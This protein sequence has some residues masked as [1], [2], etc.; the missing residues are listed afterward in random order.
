MGIDCIVSKLASRVPRTVSP[1]WG[2]GGIFGL[3]YT[4]E[5]LY[6]TVAFDAKAYFHHDDCSTEIYGYEYI[7]E[8]PRSGGDTYNAATRVDNK[9]YFGGWVH[10]PAHY[11]PSTRG[12]GE[13]LFTDKYSHVHEYDIAERKTKLLWSEK[14][15]NPR[16][17]VGEITDLLY[18]PLRDSLLVA[19][20]DGHINLGVYEIDRRKGSS[21]QVTR[22]R[23]LRSAIYADH[24]CFTLHHGWGGTP[25]IT[26]LDL[27]SYREYGIAISNPREISVDNGPLPIYRSG[28]IAALDTWIISLIRGGTITYD[29]LGPEKPWF[30]RLLDFHNSP[31]GPLRSNALSIG[32]GLLVAF[33]ASTHSTITGTDELPPEQ[34]RAARRPPAQ[35]LLVYLSP[36]TAR[37]IA[38]LGVRVTSMALAG[39]YILV[40]TNTCPN[41]ER[42]DAIRI[43]YG[44]KTIQILRHD[45]VSS[46]PPSLVLNLPGW[47]VGDSHWGGIPLTGYREVILEIKTE[48]STVLETYTYTLSTGPGNADREIHSI[49]PGKNRVDLASN[50]GLIVSLRLRRALPKATI[51]LILG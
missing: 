32:G 15:T 47:Y 29:P 45:I 36:P 4:G 42:Y 38:A 34:Q 21:A 1:E 23:V 37:I 9:I 16:L 27:E 26:C 40:A 33:N 50:S 28:D 30:T 10:A 5:A 18:N 20:G 44:V 41:L 8:P 24:A 48:K 46:T 13:V 2:C 3:T 7:G 35:T 39:P 43:D 22:T 31:Y 51:R 6:Y 12:I 11:K 49:N 14:G 19:R 17:W 25:G